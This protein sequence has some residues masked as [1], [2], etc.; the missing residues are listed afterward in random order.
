[1]NE[2]KTNFKLNDLI[3]IAERENNTRRN[4]LIVNNKQAK[5]VPVSPNEVLYLFNLLAMELKEK[6][7]K[8][9][10]VIV[11][12]AET[13]TAVGAA[14]AVA[15]GKDALYLTTTR[16]DIK[17]DYILAEFKEEHSHATEQTLFCKDEM[18]FF[19]CADRIVF[20]EDEISTGKT[21]LNFI[22]ELK[23]NGFLGQK[24]LSAVSLINSMNLEN[25]KIYNENNVECLFLVKII[26]NF[27]DTSFFGDVVLDKEINGFKNIDY[28]FFEVKG[29]KDPRVGV[30][31]LTYI[32]A[33]NNFSFFIINNIIND[34]TTNEDILVL[35][36]EEFMFP[37]IFIAEE[38]RSKFDRC[39]V[40]THSTSRSP[41]VPRIYKDYPIFNRVKLESIYENNRKTYIYN[42]R[43]YNRVI[44]LTDAEKINKNGLNDI[45]K[46]LMAYGNTNITFIRW[47]N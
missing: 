15:F 5:H 1:M 40:Y 31:A 27:A 45:S 37:A 29:K 22:N 20:V 9:K 41:I 3:G 30:N 26:N 21:I 17:K 23:S 42:L 28:N 34:I 13:A 24:K 44:I 38:I 4:Y 6:Y 36:T 18:D 32:D 16:E 33:C 10:L 2:N 39:R 35:G 47:V 14:V 11:G 19:N 43:K 7:E 25:L 8:E 12:F 46:A